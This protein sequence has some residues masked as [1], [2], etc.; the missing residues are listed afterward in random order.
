MPDIPMPLRPQ[1]WFDL[2]SVNL[3]RAA[4]HY[5]EQYGRAKAARYFRELAARIEEDAK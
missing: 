1:V 2:S 3:P 4:T 5:A